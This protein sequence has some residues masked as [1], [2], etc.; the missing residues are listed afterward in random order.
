M[1]NEPRTRNKNMPYDPSLPL[2]NSP[3]ES[4]VIRDQLQAL[5]V[6][7]NNI[8]TVTAAQVDSTNTLPQGSPANVNVSVSGGTL[9]FSFDIPQGQEGLVGPTGPP[10][11]TA[12]VDSVNTV[13]PGTPAA[14]NVGFDGTNVRFTF[15]IPR[16]ND[17]NQGQQGNDGGQGSPGNDGAQGPPFAQ[18]VVDGVT[19]LDPGQQATVQT[20][21]DGSNVRF[22]FGIPRGS[23]GSNGSDGSQGPPGDISQAQLDSAISGTSANTNGVSTLDTGFAD[24]DMEAMRQKLNEMILNGR[25]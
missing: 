25:R 1:N 21:F 24:P 15:D 7:I 19:T 13:E 9:H 11:S 18:A 2:P 20:S 14:V 6:L 5:F 23:D 3:L 17:G 12:V 8:V 10:F 22:T 16:G 4:Q